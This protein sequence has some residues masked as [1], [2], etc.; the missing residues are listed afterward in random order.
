[1][2][3][4][5][6]AVELFTAANAARQAGHDGE[7]ETCQQPDPYPR[8]AANRKRA[9]DAAAKRMEDEAVRLILEPDGC[10][11]ESSAPTLT[12]RLRT[13]V[14]F[15]RQQAKET[16]LRYQTPGGAGAADGLSDAA[17]QLARALDEHGDDK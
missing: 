1:M 14:G 12:T 16:R 15:L 7:I 4:Y 6:E 5:T 8:I 2:I 9:L 17:N 11:A 3:R 13:L 10:T